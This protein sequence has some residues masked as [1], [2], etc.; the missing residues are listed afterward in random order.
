MVGAGA[1]K[2]PPWAGP[3]VEAS[4]VFPREEEMPV[5][6]ALSLVG[7]GLRGQMP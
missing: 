2:F 6:P 4:E 1:K 7:P 3:G 5:Q